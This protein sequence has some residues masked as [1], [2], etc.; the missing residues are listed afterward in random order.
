[1]IAV[2]VSGFQHTYLCVIVLIYKP[3]YSD[4]SHFMVHDSYSFYILQGGNDDVQRNTSVSMTVTKISSIPASPEIDPPAHP[5]GSKIT[6]SAQFRSLPWFTEVQDRPN[7]PWPNAD[8]CLF[9]SWKL[10]PIIE[11]LLQ[12]ILL[13]LAKNEIYYKTEDVDLIRQF[14]EFRSDSDATLQ[15]PTPK[16][17]KLVSRLLVYRVTDVLLW[18]HQGGRIAQRPYERG[19]IFLPSRV[20]SIIY[21]YPDMCIDCLKPYNLHMN[22]WVELVQTTHSLMTPK[23][24]RPHANPSPLRVDATLK[25][26]NSICRRASTVRAEK[27]L[28]NIETAAMYL[29]WILKACVSHRTT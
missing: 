18:L 19:H 13:A 8:V 29:S 5:S 6:T 9:S 28:A 21:P 24:A 3:A 26:F 16:T 23:N 20:V 4:N 17:S 1:M 14:L 11:C 7:D 25:F 15:V 12:H 27:V 10:G 22:D 2:I